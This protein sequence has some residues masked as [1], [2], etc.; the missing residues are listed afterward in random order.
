MLVLFKNQNYVGI[1]CNFPAKKDML[2]FFH[3]GVLSVGVFPLAFYP[4]AFFCLAFFKTYQILWHLL[5]EL[6]YVDL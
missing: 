6:S 1:F 5:V 2:A 4:L 3:V